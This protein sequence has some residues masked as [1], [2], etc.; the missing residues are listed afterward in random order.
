MVSLL[1]YILV[2]LVLFSCAT[3]LIAQESMGG[4]PLSFSAVFQEKYGAALPDVQTLNVPNVKNIEQEIAKNQTDRRISIPIAC[5]FDLKN[6]GTW[7]EMPNGD[8]LWRLQLRAEAAKGLVVMYDHFYLPK[9][10]KLYA[11]TPNRL[12]VFGAYTT[13]NNSTSQR[14][15]TG[16]LND[17]AVV[18]EYYEPSAVRNQ[19]SLRIFRIDYIFEAVEKVSF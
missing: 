5:Q 16:I 8:R 12:Q 11:Y 17:D 15:L 4:F 6:S 1:R 9:G 18:I 19:G 14:F 13:K 3:L 7:T 10:S 2:H